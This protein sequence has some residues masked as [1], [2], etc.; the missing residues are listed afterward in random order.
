MKQNFHLFYKAF[1]TT[2]IFG[3]SDFVCFRQWSNIESIEVSN[4]LLRFKQQG[5]EMLY[6]YQP[7]PLFK[8]A[9]ICSFL[10]LLGV[11]TIHLLTLPL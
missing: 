6:T 5:Y 3:Y 10:L 4:V 8:Y 1:F 9:L 11:V 2:R 7:D